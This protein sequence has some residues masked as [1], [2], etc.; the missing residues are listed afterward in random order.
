M[1]LLRCS[2]FEPI[3]QRMSRSTSA[4]MTLFVRIAHKH[5]QN[6][7]TQ[8]SAQGVGCLDDY[9]K[10]SSIWL[11][12][13][14]PRR[15]M[16]SWIRLVMSLILRTRT[17]PNRSTRSEDHTQMTT[18]LNQNEHND[19]IWFLDPKGLLHQL[20]KLGSFSLQRISVLFYSF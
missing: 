5:I 4:I 10:S 16:W 3:L 14:D 11:I 13:S 15:S 2:Q 18:L 20:C 1:W 17:R 12:W 8:Q 7:E 19:S 6:L 9:L